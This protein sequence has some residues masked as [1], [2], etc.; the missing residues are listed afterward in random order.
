MISERYNIPKG[1]QYLLMFPIQNQDTD[2]TN[3]AAAINS[4]GNRKIVIDGSAPVTTTNPVVEIGFGWYTLLLTASEMNGDVIG[5]SFR[6][7]F[8]GA[9]CTITTTPVELTSIPTIN[10]TLSEKITAIFQY[11]FFKR[12]VTASQEQLYKS[13]NTT[14]LGTGTLSDDST[15]FTKGKQS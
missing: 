14:V 8:R 5:L 4:S 7:S 13:D 15:T 9:M 6:G 1:Q 10:S 2:S 12:T 3:Q 11:L